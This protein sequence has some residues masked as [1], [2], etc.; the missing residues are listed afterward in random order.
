MSET[1]GNERRRKRKPAGGRMSKTITETLSKMAKQV[2]E[3]EQNNNTQEQNQKAKHQFGGIKHIKLSDFGTSSEIRKEETGT[4]S[5]YM[6]AGL[7]LDA[8]DYFHKS[9]NACISTSDFTISVADAAQILKQISPD[10]IKKIIPFIKYDSSLN[11]FTEFGEEDP[12]GSVDLEVSELTKSQKNQSKSFRKPK[13]FTKRPD[14]SRPTRMLSPGSNS[15]SPVSAAV[16]ALISIS[17]PVSSKTNTITQSHVSEPKPILTKLNKK[18]STTFLPLTKPPIGVREY[19]SENVFLPVHKPEPVMSSYQKSNISTSATTETEVSEVMSI[20][21]K[22]IEIGGIKNT[23][24]NQVTFLP[25]PSFSHPFNNNSI[26]RLN[27]YAM[28]QSMNYN[29]YNQKDVNQV[30]VSSAE[31][32]LPQLSVLLHAQSLPD[33]QCSLPSPYS[34]VVLPSSFEKRSLLL[35]KKVRVKNWDPGGNLLPITYGG[36]L[37]VVVEMRSCYV[38]SGAVYSFMFR[39]NIIGPVVLNFTNANINK[40]QRNSKRRSYGSSRIQ[41]LLKNC[42]ILF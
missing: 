14:A 7:K 11:T 21:K 28:R 33:M 26:T 9:L 6:G 38:K 20:T 22:Q 29:L 12:V 19:S 25:H 17:A 13:T 8:F 15:C 18:A 31:D 2:D 34:Q 27:E 16:Q 23:V 5:V 30:S 10:I 35:P 3:V 41:K 1:D 4:N 42:K 40:L 37:Q 32:T 36:P 24:Q 39:T